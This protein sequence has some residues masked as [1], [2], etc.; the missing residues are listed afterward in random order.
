[1]DIWRL[2]PFVPLIS[3]DFLVSPYPVYDSIFFNLLHVLSRLQQ[4]N[5]LKRNLL[6]YNLLLGTRFYY[7]IS[8]LLTLY[9]LRCSLGMI[10][11][12]I[13]HTG[14]DPRVAIVA[15]IDIIAQ[16]KAFIQTSIN[17]PEKVLGFSEE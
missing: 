4:I 16:L 12:G 6:G 5:L 1:M 15:K 2:V 14:T 11:G 8:S 3:I 13:S 9:Y 17:S 7:P 10:C